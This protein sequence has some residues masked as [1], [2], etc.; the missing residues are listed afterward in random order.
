MFSPPSLMSPHHFRSHMH[1]STLN[2]SRRER[3]GLREVQ[4]HHFY[5]LCIV[6]Q[7]VGQMKVTVQ[8]LSKCLSV[9]TVEILSKTNMNVLVVSDIT[10]S[11]LTRLKNV[12][13]NI[14]VISDYYWKLKSSENISYI[15]NITRK[16]VGS[17]NL[18][19]DVFSIGKQRLFLIID[20]LWQHCQNTHS[21]H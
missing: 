18:K 8:T 9:I 16:Q 10:D 21:L 5:V 15:S 4:W 17:K 2:Q 11:K 1:V 3:G 14:C 20:T 7:V 12:N 19:K 6:L 13:K